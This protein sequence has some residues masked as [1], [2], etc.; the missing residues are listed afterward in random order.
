MLNHCKKDIRGGWDVWCFVSSCVTQ[1]SHY[2]IFTKLLL[3]SFPN[4]IFNQAPAPARHQIQL[5]GVLYF[6]LSTTSSSQSWLLS[7][8]SLEFFHTCQLLLIYSTWSY[9]EHPSFS[10]MISR[11]GH[12][13]GMNSSTYVHGDTYFRDSFISRTFMTNV[14]NLHRSPLDL[15][16]WQK[17]I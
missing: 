13:P 12:P 3:S 8:V 4:P 14:S 7:S 6:S 17:T 10:N 16:S 1:C 11:G 2:W 15:S 9:Q 5:A